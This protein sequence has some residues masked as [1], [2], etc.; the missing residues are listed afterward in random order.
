MGMPIWPQG[1]RKNQI[2]AGEVALSFK[3][4]NETKKRLKIGGVLLGMVI[5]IEFLCAPFSLALN[6]IEVYRLK[7]DLAVAKANWQTQAVQDYDIT[8]RGYVPLACVYNASLTVK[9]G[10]L[11]AVRV[12][13]G[14]LIDDPPL[15][16]LLEK[17]GWDNGLCSYSQLTVAGMFEKVEENLRTINPLEAEIVVEFD[18]EIG[19]ITKYEYN[20]G[21][22]GRLLGPVVGDCCIWYKFG[23]FSPIGNNN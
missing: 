21:Y 5:C 19:F 18:S 8:V 14:L 1:K 17:D 22:P 20:Y 6:I 11:A 15:T 2:R 23:N 7:R 16:K 10:T 3:V 9:E 12:G 4:S 13:R